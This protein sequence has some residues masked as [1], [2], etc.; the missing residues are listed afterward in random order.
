MVSFSGTVSGQIIIN[1][2]DELVRLI[3]LRTNNNIP[4]VEIDNDAKKIIFN[5]GKLIIGNSCASFYE[6]GV[7]IEAT[8]YCIIE[9]D[10]IN[11][12]SISK[13][14]TM[15]DYKTQMHELNMIL[16]LDTNEEE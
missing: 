13:K 16:I 12:T 6:S 5:L 2:S 14:I 11:Y 9:G 1:V 8:S 4:I 10:N 3:C 15:I 7:S